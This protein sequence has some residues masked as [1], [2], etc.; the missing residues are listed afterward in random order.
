MN[1]PHIRNSLTSF[2]IINNKDESILM[3]AINYLNI[4][5]SLCHHT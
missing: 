2:K 5:A 3:I 4:Y 1:F